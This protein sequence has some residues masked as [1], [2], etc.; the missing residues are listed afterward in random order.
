VPDS[1]LEFAVATVPPG[2]WGVGV[3]GGADSVALLRLLFRSA[4]LS[5]HV[6]H[7]DHQTRGEQSTTDA[8]FVRELARHNALPFTLA[9]RDQLEPG[10]ADLPRN[11]S[12]RYRALRLELFRRAAHDHSLQGVI[13][14]HHADDQAETILHRLVRGSSAAGLGGMSD[15]NRIAG[16]L[17][18]RPLLSIGRNQLR[19]YL[20]AIGQ[21]WREDASNSSAQYTRN[22]LRQ[23]LKDDP[24][25]RA[26]LLNL[27][28][29]SR[30]LRLWVRATA[31]RLP[32]RFAASE[33]ARL[34]DVL[35]RQAAR[36]WLED[37]G[38]A[39]NDLSDEILDRLLEM[40]SDAATAPRAHFPGGIAVVRK[41]RMIRVVAPPE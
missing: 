9:R 41:A 1:S 30:D 14:A 5:L 7:L 38:A 16:L 10:V 18:L 37:H 21:I 27:G 29:A 15:Q 3:S 31:P 22:R 34:P 6:I 32:E 23:L 39:P 26:A 12:A 35:A 13:L 36:Q 40:A 28:E 25:L 33:L 17:I 20:V 4:D 24:P 2:R 11:P 8:E 19:E